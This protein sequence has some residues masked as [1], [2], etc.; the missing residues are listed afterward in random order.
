MATVNPLAD[1]VETYGDRLLAGVSGIGHWS[2][3][4]VSALECR[5]GGD[6]GDYDTAAA[7]D[8]LAESIPQYSLARA[9][10]L[11]K[12]S[13]FANR[14]TMV[15]ALRAWLDAELFNATFD[16]FR[17]SSIVGGHNFNL[18]YITRNVHQFDEEPE[19][20]DPLLGVEALDPNIAACTGEIVGLCG[21]T[22][23]VGGACASG[24]LALRAGFRDIV[25]GDCDLSVVSSAAFD[26]SAV[27]IQASVILNALPVE[28]EFQ[29]HPERAS[30]P[31]DTRRCGFVPSHGT[32]TMILEELNCARRRGA[33]I[34]AE[35]LGVAANANGDHLPAPSAPFQARIMQQLLTAT[36]THPEQVDYVNCHATSTPLGDLE[37]V[38]AIKAAFG[39]HAWRLKLNAPKSMLGHTCWAAPIVETIGGLVQMQR[40]Q[41]HTTINVDEVDPEIDLDICANEPQE[42]ETVYML[43][44]AFGFGGINCCSLYRRWDS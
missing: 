30:R 35:L 2:S 13:T 33:P 27:D 5:I 32:G 7:L 38:R 9:R 25:T 31:F 42:H 14:L 8:S 44:N 20:I 1:D 4:D 39:D 17:A 3:I 37:E 40:G 18:R 23:T 29:Q 43:K 11:F 22:L 21:P 16:P 41:L 10:K 36:G 28:P 19:Y 12:T 24:N 6:L 15:C 34:W 26:M